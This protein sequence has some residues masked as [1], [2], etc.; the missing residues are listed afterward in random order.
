MRI[1]VF[2]AGAVGALFGGRLAEAGGDV[3]LVARGAHLEA[4]QRDGLVL[5]TPDGARRV[6]VT[7]AEDPAAVGPCDA[8]L[9]CVKAYDT[10]AV[11]ARLH[12]LLHARTAVVSLQN[13]VDNERRIAEVVGAG[14]VLGGVAFVFATAV[15]PGVVE[16]RGQPPRIVLGEL[17][18]AVTERATA[19]AAALN[20]AGIDTTASEDIGA[21][22]WHK[23]AFIC[24]VAGLTAA[25][26]L[27]LGVIRSSPSAWGL[28]ERLVHEVCALAEAEDVGLPPDTAEQ[29]IAAAWTLDPAS[30]SSLHDDLVHGR[31][32]ELDALHGT[33]LRLARRHG[34]S[35]PMCAAVHAI[36]QPWAQR[37]EQREGSS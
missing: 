16:Q 5:R 33:A 10:D 18:G 2:G 13:G 36:L 12:P 23:Y 8:V 27:P 28:F 24:A 11:A 29:V 31:R 22:L 25:V 30:R 32:M 6:A 34:L 3:R 7:A 17:D 35:L 4:L 15:A 26:R 21:V 19:L 20:A 37:N 9:V 14:H 1:A